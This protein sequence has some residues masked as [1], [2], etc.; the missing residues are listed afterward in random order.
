MAKRQKPTST[1]AMDLDTPPN[2]QPKNSVLSANT[3]AGISKSTRLPRGKG[4][5]AQRLRKEKG[6]E[7]AEEVQ[8]RTERKVERSKGRGRVR[9]ERNAKW[10]DLNQKIK[11]AIVESKMLGKA[12]VDALRAD[13]GEGEWVDDGGGMVDLKGAVDEKQTMKVLENGA[14]TGHG[15][16]EMAEVED[17]IS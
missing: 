13:E 8:A 17:G 1:T 12:K 15:D 3:R 14:T 9:G 7:R 5:R 4:R 6:A 16:G 11:G 10:E 2:L